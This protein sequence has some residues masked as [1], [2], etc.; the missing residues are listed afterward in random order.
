M[1]SFERKLK[2]FKEPP[3]LFTLETKDELAQMMI[4][5][6]KQLTVANRFD[7]ASE[8]EQLLKK[9]KSCEL[10]LLHSLGKTKEIGDQL[11]SLK[12][13]AP[14]AYIRALKLLGRDNEAKDYCDIV[15]Y[16]NDDLYSV[17]LEESWKLELVEFRKQNALVTGETKI[18]L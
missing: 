2:L 16:D 7:E 17:Y 13:Q 4:E 11:D 3:V 5:C 1:V 18:K 8:L 14:L 9:H 12:E 15:C 10:S 6:Y